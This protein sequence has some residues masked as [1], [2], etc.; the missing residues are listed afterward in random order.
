MMAA[1]VMATTTWGDQPQSD[2]VDCHA[3]TGNGWDANISASVM[4]EE[5]PYQVSWFQ[6]CS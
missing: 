1:V 2:T 3:H 5:L 4:I 6:A